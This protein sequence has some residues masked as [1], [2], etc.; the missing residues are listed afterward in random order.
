MRYH[1]ISRSC[2]KLCPS[3]AENLNVRVCIQTIGDETYCNVGGDIPAK[4][5]PGPCG[6]KTE[7]VPQT[8]PVM[9]VVVHMFNHRRVQLL[10]KVA[11]QNREGAGRCPL[12]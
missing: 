4:K 8:N 10:E 2:E 12:T 5:N 3:E 6:L 7:W 11:C 1:L 9:G